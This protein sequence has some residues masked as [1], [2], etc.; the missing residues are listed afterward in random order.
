MYRSIGPDHLLVVN[1]FRAQQFRLEL[2]ADYLEDRQWN[3]PLCADDRVGLMDVACRGMALAE[4]RQQPF[5]LLICTGAVA[6]VVC[7]VGPD[8]LGIGGA[9]LQAGQL[10]GRSAG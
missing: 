4:R 10:L 8:V 3:P 5:Q 2:S 6:F 9:G 1:R 7:F